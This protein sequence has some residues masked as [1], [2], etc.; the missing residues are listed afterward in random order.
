MI[1]AVSYRALHSAGN[2]FN[3]VGDDVSCGEGG[4]VEARGGGILNAVQSVNQDLCREL[5]LGAVHLTAVLPSFSIAFDSLNLQL[6]SD[7]L[8]VAHVC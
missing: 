2:N 5:I 1:P 4:G 6:V 7:L 8:A 3:V